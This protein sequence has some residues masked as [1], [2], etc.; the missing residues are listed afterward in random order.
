MPDPLRGS[1]ISAPAA[2][3]AEGPIA[4]LRGLHKRFGAQKVLDGVSLDF[5][6]GRTTVVLGPS[7]SG[8]SV[9]LRHIV[10]LL[11]P[12]RGEVLFRGRRIDNLRERELFAVRRE[13][14]FLFQLSALFDSMTIRE[15]LEFP[16]TE[17][18]DLGPESRRQRVA[19]ALRTVD[20]EGAMDKVPSQLSGGQQKRVALARAI[21][22]RPALILYDEPTTG[23]DPIRADGIN[24]LIVK[25]QRELGVTSIVVTHDLVS[26]QAVSDRVIMLYEGKIIADGPLPAVRRS[27]DPHVQNFLRG[28]YE[29]DVERTAVAAGSAEEN[30]PDEPQPSGQ[31]VQG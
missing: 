21:I 6:T 31:E 18:T 19:E 23:L 16:L 26:A 9:L 17:H 15:N 24:Q 5:A 29:D 13:I 30:G 7:G 28:V 27:G 11:R 2:A 22:L 4:S 20:L 1:P 3:P 8:K 12:D 10:G 25:L 14:G